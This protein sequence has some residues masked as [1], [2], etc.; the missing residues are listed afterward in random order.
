MPVRGSRICPEGGFDW[1]SGVDGAA[2]P[3]GPNA[4]T[5]LAGTETET[6]TGQKALTSLSVAEQ[7]ILARWRS[8]G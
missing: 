1:P 5:L 4:L 3:T 6:A 2:I 8:L 7:D